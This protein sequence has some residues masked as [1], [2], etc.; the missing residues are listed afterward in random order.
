MKPKLS[1]VIATLGGQILSET[2]KSI[3]TGKVLPDEVILCVPEENAHSVHS[4]G[5]PNVKILKTPFRGQVRQRAFGFVNA[6]G[7]YILQLD[8]DLIIE[9]DCIEIMLKELNKLP[10]NS[11]ISP[12][13]MVLS[14]GQSFYKQPS[15]SVIFRLY[16]YLLNGSTGY[17]SGTITLAGTNIGVDPS[18]FLED[19]TESQWL[20][21][22]CIL[23]KRENIITDDFYPFKGKAFCED[24]YH[25]FLLQQKE[26]RMFFANRAVV[27]LADAEKLSFRMKVKNLI[28]DF[29]AR[30]RF[31]S[32]YKADT[33]YLR[34]YIYYLTN[35]FR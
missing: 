17:K 20:P 13:L 26:I 8:D 3:N 7:D 22:G 24:L 30:R 32:Y 10:A 27:W 1:V 23:H 15:D 4:F 19:L 18:L 11:C 21:G 2:V 31:L 16:Y 12:S 9:P 34:L 35:F 25:S 5:Y 6:I 33:S 14:T 28:A 29:H